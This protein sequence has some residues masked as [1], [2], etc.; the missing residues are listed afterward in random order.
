LRS[1]LDFASAGNPTQEFASLLEKATAILVK[2]WC[3]FFL[4]FF[5]FFF[6]LNF[7]S[8]QVM[9]RE[10][11][12]A[13]NVACDVF[14]KPIEYCCTRKNLRFLSLDKFFLPIWKRVPDVAV[15]LFPRIAEKSGSN[16]WT[17]PARLAAVLSIADFVLRSGKSHLIQHPTLVVGCVQSLE[18]AFLTWLRFENGKTKSVIA[19]QLVVSVRSAY[20]DTLTDDRLGGMEPSQLYNALPLRSDVAQALDALVLK[21][22]QS[23]KLQHAAK[24]L[25]KL[26]HLQQ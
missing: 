22:A 6:F 21:H 19:A 3:F 11:L 24:K 1:V 7:I 15:L 4:F 26:F 17:Q 16:N 14:L 5:F 12:L 13:A 20:F 2:V 8:K 9:S 23:T 10:N 18:R 25:K